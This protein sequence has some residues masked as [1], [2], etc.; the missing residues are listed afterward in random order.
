MQLL[1]SRFQLDGYHLI[2][3][4]VNGLMV[5]DNFIENN[6]KHF[7]SDK[8]L[9]YKKKP[10][11]APVQPKPT[12]FFGHPISVPELEYEEGLEFARTLQTIFKPY[13]RKLP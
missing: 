12:H 10:L 13:R 11:Y 9:D 8:Y 3:Y 2:T 7:F 1:L 5:S 4:A 6:L